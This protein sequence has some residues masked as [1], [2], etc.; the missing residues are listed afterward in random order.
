[1][2]HHSFE[3]LLL[4]QW[5]QNAVRKGFKPTNQTTDQLAASN[6]PAK[7]HEPASSQQPTGKQQHSNII[8][9]NNIII[10]LY[11]DITI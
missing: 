8:I 9:Y 2:V 7:S 5:L 11:N 1:M 6:Q 4:S 3:L 10:Y